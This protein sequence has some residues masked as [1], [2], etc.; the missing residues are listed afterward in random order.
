M[1]I[2]VVGSFVLLQALEFRGGLHA[3]SCAPHRRIRL[4]VGVIVGDARSG[5]F[6]VASLILVSLFMSVVGL[7]VHV[8]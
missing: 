5:A 1:D 8:G 2:N 7:F 6:A 4:E 3:S